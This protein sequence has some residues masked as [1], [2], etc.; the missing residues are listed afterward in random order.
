MVV[1]IDGCKQGRQYSC[2]SPG[3]II[4]KN[5][6]LHLVSTFSMHAYTRSSVS[7]FWTNRA[8]DRFWGFDGAI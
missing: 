2:A 3:A 4:A 7:F 8:C 1:E 5:N 6:A